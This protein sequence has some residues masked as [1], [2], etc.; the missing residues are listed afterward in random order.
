MLKKTK[1][2]FI[3]LLIILFTIFPIRFAKSYDG[4]YYYRGIKLKQQ[5]TKSILYLTPVRKRLE[6]YILMDL[7]IDPDNDEINTV[8]T[9]ISFPPDKLELK[10]FSKKSS[11]C[12]FFIEEEINNKEGWAKIS[13]LKPYPGIS[14]LSNV[15]GLV[16]EEKK[17][18]EANITLSKDSMVLANDG[19]GTNVLKY[20][21]DK[22]II[23]Y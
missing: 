22:R 11:F 17:V 21:R 13:C 9:L 10:G 15:V 5:E 3:F 7:V 14:K 18:G 19:Y 1:K 23:I 4:N 6:N 20:T 16:F 2:S 12:S 8:S